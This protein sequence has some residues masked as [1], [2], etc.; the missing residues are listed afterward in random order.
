MFRGESQPEK[1]RKTPVRFV[2]NGKNQSAADI[3][4]SA[5]DWYGWQAPAGEPLSAAYASR[6][7]VTA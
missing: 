1:G 7:K 6:W 2:Q 4:P 5:A 3:V